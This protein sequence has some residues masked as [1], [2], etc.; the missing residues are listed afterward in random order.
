MFYKILETVFT[1]PLKRE[2]T[3][4][5]DEP[6]TFNECA[7]ERVHIINEEETGV[8]PNDQPISS[9]CTKDAVSGENCFCYPFFTAIHVLNLLQIFI[10]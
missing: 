4:G 10:K 6:S 2:R 9:T 5:P 3:F 7:Q 8:S 1:S